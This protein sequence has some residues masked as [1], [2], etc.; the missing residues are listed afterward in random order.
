MP[1]ME[2]WSR[3]A[4]QALVVQLQVC[5]RVG[6]PW[7]ACAAAMVLLEMVKVPL[8]CC[9]YVKDVDQAVFFLM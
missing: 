2:N 5:C 1:E 3:L 7:S 8:L 9:R 6:V 4:T